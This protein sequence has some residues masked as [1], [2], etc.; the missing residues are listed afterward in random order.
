MKLLAVENHP[1]QAAMKMIHLFC[2][3][4]KTEYGGDGRGRAG[5]RSSG[6]S[7]APS[8]LVS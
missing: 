7:L 6:G 1:A 3:G 2:A 5:E 4:L 8:L